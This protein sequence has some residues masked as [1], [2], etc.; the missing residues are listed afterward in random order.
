MSN[1]K[2][3][4]LLAIGAH[5]AD[6]ELAAGLLIAKYTR[7]GHEATLLSL[8]PGERGHA[9]L[10]AEEYAGQKRREA[11]ACC[12]KLG[13]DT[14]ILDYQDAELPYNDEVTFK[15]CDIIRERKPDIV[16]THWQS[17][18]H[19]DHRHAHKVAMD[20]LFYAALPRLEREL[21][22]HWTQRVFFSENWEDMEGYEPDIYVEIDEGTFVQYTEALAEFEL[23]RGGT[24]WPYADYYTSLARLRG[25]LGG[26]Q[27]WTYACTLKVPP[28]ALVQRFAA[29][30]LPFGS[31]I[32]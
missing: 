10:S 18:I 24:G 16:V 29:A 32:V 1:A 13:A 5:A 26:G 23:W 17:S 30:G 27:G 22:A 8:T 31:A 6:Q 7:A 11:A 19:R 12:E 14:V 25:C 4:K 2:P 9:R 3:L 20:A 28:D 15:V 21:P